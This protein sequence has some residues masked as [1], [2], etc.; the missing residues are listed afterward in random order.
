MLDDNHIICLASELLL[1]EAEGE[2][3][4]EQIGYSRKTNIYL[5]PINC[6]FV[7]MT[8]REMHL[9]F[10]KRHKLFRL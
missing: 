8:W 10:C 2:N 3:G 9:L 6:L 1:G 7:W 4:T 5:W